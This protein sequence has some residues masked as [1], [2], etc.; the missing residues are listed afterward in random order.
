MPIVRAAI[1]LRACPHRVVGIGLI[2]VPL[3]WLFATW[4]KMA[5]KIIAFGTWAADGRVFLEAYYYSD[6]V[7]AN[8]PWM[9]SGAVLLLVSRHWE[10]S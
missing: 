3:L 10:G 6:I 5:I 9:L 4:V 8:A 2:A 1:Q 7:T